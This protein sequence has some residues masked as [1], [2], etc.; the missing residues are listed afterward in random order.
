LL[1]RWYHRQFGE[2]ADDYF[3]REMNERQRRHAQL[4]EF[5]SGIWANCSK[6]YNDKLKTAVQKKIAGEICG[7]RRVRPQ[8]LCLRVGKNIFMTK[9]DVGAVNERRCREAAHHWIA[10]GRYCEAA[11]EL[12]S[13]EGICARVRCGEGFVLLQQLQQLESL[14]RDQVLLHDAR[15]LH[16]LRRLE[17]YARW[18]K[19]D[20]STIAAD[21]VT[22]TIT[23]CSRQPEISYPRKDL[24]SYLL[25]PSKGTKYSS[26]SIFSSFVLGPVVHSTDPCIMEM[27][28][29]S[30]ACSIAYNAD[31]SLLAAACGNT[32]SLWNM[33]TGAVEGVL[34]GHKNS[35]LSVAWHGHQL[36]SCESKL[37][38]PVLS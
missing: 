27:R 13:V 26:D 30:R 2:A 20:M 19:K 10:A 18:L 12:C 25:L 22:E 3:L 37:R 14:I 21:P 15:A 16:H 36:E 35:V 8:P 4:G 33:K 28:L 9:G 7:D 23:T 29:Q 34:K 6:P 24:A 32:V 31:S 5:F 38:A 11:D 1:M 17:H